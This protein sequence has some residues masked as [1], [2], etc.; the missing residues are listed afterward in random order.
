MIYS[1]AVLLLCAFAFSHVQGRIGQ[2][3][4]I[5]HRRLLCWIRG[6]TS[7]GV[8]HPLLVK[9]GDLSPADCPWRA[10]KGFPS[11]KG[12]RKLGTFPQ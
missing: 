6:C 10:G 7:L 1:K 12:S 5:Q 4:L 11:P 3:H 9:G 2:R 8:P